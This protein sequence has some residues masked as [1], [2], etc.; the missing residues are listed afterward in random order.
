MTVEHHSQRPA[1]LSDD[2]PLD[3]LTCCPECDLLMEKIDIPK[4]SAAKCPR[5]NCTL[6]HN[7]RHP[8]DR[9][10]AL[11]LTS[12]ILFIPANILPI[13]TM[14][15]LGRKLEG[16]TMT[17]VFEMLSSG[18]FSVGVLVFLTSVM[19][20][21]VQQMAL[22]Y[23][24]L[25]LKFKLRTKHTIQFFKFYQWLKPWAMI[26]IYLLGILL[27]CLKLEDDGDV[28]FQ[29]GFYA[30]SGFLLTTILAIVSLDSTYV[31]SRLDS[32]LHK[33]SKQ[34]SSPASEGGL[35]SS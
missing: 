30:L 34:K 3:R 13:M 26:E 9:T 8:I 6:Y 12:L 23:V 32:I 15:L 14:D 21:V 11:S 33:D 16:I 10:L 24:L 25:H 20:P 35:M 4:G 31:W 19:I 7:K 1:K 22:T 27:S 2:I 28:I 18:F 17:G 5:C 29:A